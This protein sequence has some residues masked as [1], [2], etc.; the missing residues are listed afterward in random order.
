[1]FSELH[2]WMMFG[3]GTGTDEKREIKMKNQPDVEP[4]SL[5]GRPLTENLQLNRLH[6]FVVDFCCVAAA[7]AFSQSC[8][9]HLSCYSVQQPTLLK[10]T[11]TREIR[12]ET[13]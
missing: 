11:Q 8:D 6:D 7:V 10:N 9:P 2:C 13:L 3:L 5:R 4:T 1:M 12:P